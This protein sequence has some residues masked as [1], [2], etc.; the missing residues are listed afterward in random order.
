MRWLAAIPVAAVV[1]LTVTGCSQP[2][3]GAA[4][5]YGSQRIS[6]RQLADEVANLNTAYQAYKSKLQI[7]YP[8]AEMPR[9]VLSWM[10]EFAT[11]DQ[12]AASDG[13]HVSK[14]QALAQE[15]AVARQASQA[16][17]TLHEVAV[18][19]GLPPNMLP[20]VGH[21]LAI[22]AVLERQLTGGV[23][24][25]TQAAATALQVKVIHMECLAA[26]GMNIRVNP[27]FGAFDYGQFIVVAAPQSLSATGGAGGASPAPAP[28]LTPA[29]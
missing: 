18:L 26:K 27:Q 4:A 23:A 19:A 22:R 3:I 1:A 7:R 24:P 6:A 5:L 21:W 12:I 15:T 9:K 2:Q 14:T 20:Q 13:I 28:Q 29:C 17:D 25:R 10:L 16:G 8:P 11:Y